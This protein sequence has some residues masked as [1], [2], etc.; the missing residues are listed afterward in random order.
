MVYVGTQ[1]V[2]VGLHIVMPEELISLNGLRVFRVG[3]TLHIPLP[4]AFWRSCGVCLCDHCNGKEGF[5]DALGVN[6]VGDPAY[7]ANTTWMVHAPD[8]QLRIK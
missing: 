2:R 3:N 4:K 7:G 5:W 6:A 8:L 1:V